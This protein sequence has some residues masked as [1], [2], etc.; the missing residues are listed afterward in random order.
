MSATDYSDWILGV[1]RKAEQLRVVF[2]QLGSSNE[3]ARRALGASQVNVTRVRTTC[4]QMAH[5][6]PEQS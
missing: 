4:S 1:H 3:P 6:P 5:L 2:L